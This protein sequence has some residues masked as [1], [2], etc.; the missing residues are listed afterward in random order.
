MA[1]RLNSEEA[2]QTLAAQVATQAAEIHRRY[3][4]EI[5]WAELSRLLEDRN[6]VRYPCEIRFDSAPLLPGE[7][8]HP[9]P[10]GR[11]PDD[12]FIIYVHPAFETQLDRVSY[13]VLHQLVW[14]NFGVSAE[15]DDAETFG[16]LALGL[17]KEEYYSALCELAG[18]LGGD[19]LV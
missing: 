17:A 9:V 8:A 18:Q 10:K 1:R 6:C 2:R 11:E 4:P 16:A 3:G 14:V 19:E 5:G 7:F 12:G 15:A 13:L